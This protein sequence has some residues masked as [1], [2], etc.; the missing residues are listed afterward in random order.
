MEVTLKVMFLFIGLV[1]SFQLIAL[2]EM[3]LLDELLSL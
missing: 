1:V 2:L 3:S